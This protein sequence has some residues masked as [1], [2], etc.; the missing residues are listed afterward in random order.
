MR[1]IFDSPEDLAGFYAGGLLFDRFETP[2]ARLAA[3]TAVT[4]ARL[5]EMAELL[6]QPDRLNVLA[7]GLLEDGEDDRLEDVVKGFK[8]PR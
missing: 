7:V 8:G 5:R 6:A 2:E 3:N 4:P 1:T